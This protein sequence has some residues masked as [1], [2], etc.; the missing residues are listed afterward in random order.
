MNY[1][2][3][4]DAAL[5]Y[6]KDRQVQINY[7][8]EFDNAIKFIKS[9]TIEDKDTILKAYE[10]VMDECSSERIILRCS[11]SGFALGHLNPK[12]AIQDKDLVMCAIKYDPEF[13]FE[14]KKQATPYK[15]S[16]YGPLKFRDTYKRVLPK[17][18][19]EDKDVALLLGVGD[20]PIG[21]KFKSIPSKLRNN[22]DFFFEFVKTP[23]FSSH[24]YADV[25]IDFEQHKDRLI[26]S[27]ME[28]KSSDLVNAP[29]WLREDPDVMRALLINNLNYR[30]GYPCSKLEDYVNGSLDL[31]RK[32]DAYS[33][34]D[35]QI[36]V[37]N[38]VIKFRDELGIDVL[39]TS[40]NIQEARAVI[41]MASN[42]ES[43]LVEKTTTTE[44]VATQ[45]PRRQKI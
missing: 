18:Y 10:K 8:R 44:S 14:T 17:K 26:K 24:F 29:V 30:V 19:L 13:Y 39:K 45:K 1:Q 36:N 20:Y 43:I 7:S 9:A 31:D 42:L 28:S 37:L 27:V 40:K 11:L 34:A 4:A 15:D 33:L 41:E 23:N 21:R 16:E 35:K 22:P 12:L 2:E 25:D 32:E 3:I 38:D 6:L 5:K